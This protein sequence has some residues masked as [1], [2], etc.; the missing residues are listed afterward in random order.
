MSGLAV[1][2]MVVVCG[3]VWGGFALLLALALRHEG[4]RRG[5]EGGAERRD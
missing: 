5:G 3:L 2:V 4:A 1:A